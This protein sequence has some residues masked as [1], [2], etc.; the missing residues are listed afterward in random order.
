MKGFITAIKVSRPIF[1]VLTPL[2]YY[3]GIKEGGATISW[4]VIAEMAML[5]FPYC[6]YLLGLNDWYDIPSD[7]I[8][9]Q[10][11]CPGKKLIGGMPDKQKLEAIKFSFW[12]IPLCFLVLSVL[13]GR[14]IHI[15]PTVVLMVLSYIYSAPPRLKCTLFIDSIT[16]GAAIPLIFLMGFTLGTGGHIPPQLWTGF[17]AF[18]GGH[19]CGAVYDYK[20]DLLAGNKTTAVRL[21]ITASTLLAAAYLLVA[22]FI[23]SLP[24]AVIVLLSVLTAMCILYLVFRKEIIMLI[25]LLLGLSTLFVFIIYMVL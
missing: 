5:S 1:W 14:L 23:S 11:K 6:L 24:S 8:K 10:K 22:I 12:L 3:W 2:G 20:P 7:T 21:G 13:S 25:T 19:L 15:V 4:L 9:F 17:F 16:N 18:T